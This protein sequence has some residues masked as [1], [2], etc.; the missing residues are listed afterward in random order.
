[1]Y[2]TLAHSQ[3]F[4]A[5]WYRKTQ[6]A[7]WEK[8]ADPLWHYLDR[9]WKS[10]LNPSPLFDT[11]YYLESN[12]DVVA[13]KLNPLFHYLAYGVG[14]RRSPVRSSLQALNERSAASA[15]L[16]I[17]EV[18]GRLAGRMT[19]I[20]DDLTP[21]DSGVAYFAPLLAA[22]TIAQI[23]GERLR[24]FDR[25]SYKEDLAVARLLQLAGITLVEG[26]ELTA[27]PAGQRDVEIVVYS[28]E[29][30]AVTSWSSALAAVGSVGRDRV[31]SL[32]F[33]NEHRLY[34]DSDAL[35][36]V[37]ER[38]RLGLV[39]AGLRS[40]QENRIKKSPSMG[41]L[42]VLTPRAIGERRSEA[43]RGTKP[44]IMWDLDP[45]AS[46]SMVGFTLRCL[47][48]VVS[49]SI[50][51][52]DSY[53][54]VAIAPDQPVRKVLNSEYLETVWQEP[55]EF[56][57]TPNVVGDVL[58]ALARPD[59][60]GLLELRNLSSHGTVITRFRGRTDFP[61]RILS[62]EARVEEVV[63]ALKIATDKPEATRFGGEFAVDA[64]FRGL[65]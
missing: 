15:P 46:G 52:Q 13:I 22:A 54:H 39:L 65:N 36:G 45:R 8:I 43:P 42:F 24:V 7:G 49:H 20:L 1:M 55:D 5:A 40:H 57:H 60:L 4:D 56:L 3:Y 44:R 33:D 29:L 64:A 17:V 53:E 35:W 50:V 58:V 26:W 25:R 12:P 30:V 10:G 19:V 9:G 21:R 31:L 2:R 61:G 37:H 28:E 6:L 51:G 32:I 62:V 27:I 34:G 38:E 41:G 14:E 11:E 23:R 48:H 47:E 16:E 18:P 59:Y 63:S